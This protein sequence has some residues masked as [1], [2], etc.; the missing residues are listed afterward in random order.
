MDDALRAVEVAAQV[1]PQLAFMRDSMRAAQAH[2]QSLGFAG[3]WVRGMVVHALPYY[4]WYKVQCGDG[5]G[6]QAAC[7]LE[8]CGLVP[9][10]PRNISPLPPGSLVMLYLP[11]GFN[12]GF[13]AG[14]VPP[15]VAEGKVVCPDW[16]VQGGNSGIKREDAHKFP[17]KNLYKEGGVRD[18]SSQRP[19]DATA[20]EEGWVT[21]TGLAVTIDDFFLQ[22]RVN[23]MCGL[24]MSWYD[25][26]CRL[27]GVQLHIESSIHEEACVEDEGEAHY[28]RGYA[29]YPWEG[30]GL[31]DS[32]TDIAKEYTDK[33]VQY[34]KAVGKVDL[35]E[36]EEDVQPLYRAREYG[37]YMGQ[38]YYR[39]VVKPAKQSG[40]RKFKDDASPPDEGLFREHI[41]LDGSYCIA[42]AKRLAFLKRCKLVSPW[43]K[44]LPEDQNGDDQ[45]KNNYKFSGKT[46][47]GPEHK[48]K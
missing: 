33:E 24:F 14:A 37:G 4:H 10:G 42:S 47:G 35:P 1:V 18:F 21:P 7:K 17:I 26:W 41:G 31:Y 15:M 43:Q 6:W 46:G 39:E 29:T 36:G 25:S 2:M 12:Y 48:M 5:F 20:F 9:V 38:G 19:Q 22:V 27:A 23:E 44:K 3:H 28:F 8:S 30:I 34:T 45:K 11:K 16:V 32:G 40:K 13:I